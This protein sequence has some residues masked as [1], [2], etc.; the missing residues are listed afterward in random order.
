MGQNPNRALTLA[1]LAGFL[2]QRNIRYVEFQG[3]A[4][5]LLNARV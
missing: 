5:H 4:E 1:L 3:A 2:N